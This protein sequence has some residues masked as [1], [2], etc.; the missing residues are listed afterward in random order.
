MTSLPM[1]GGYLGLQVA[2]V[3]IGGASIGAIDPNGPSL[4]AGL[5][6]TDV[7]IAVDSAPTANATAVHDLL[8]ER[9]AGQIVTLTVRRGGAVI[10]MQ[11]TLAPRMRRPGL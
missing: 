10:P 5:A 7:I 6:P 9:P 1:C 8:R 11:V 2:N 4:G 3:S